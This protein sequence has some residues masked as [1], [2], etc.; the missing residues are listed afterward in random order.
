M[1]DNRIFSEKATV[2]AF[3]YSLFLT[4]NGE[5]PTED[6]FIKIYEQYTED[7]RKTEK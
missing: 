1:S 7:E 5:P 3:L 4:I 6:E 2:S